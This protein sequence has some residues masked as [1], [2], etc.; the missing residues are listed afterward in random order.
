MWLDL[1]NDYTMSYAAN[2]KSY[3][4]AFDMNKSTEYRLQI[5]I[6]KS[7][8]SIQLLQFETSE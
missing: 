3:N 4:T 1:K 6:W 8:K 5:E 2:P 7:A